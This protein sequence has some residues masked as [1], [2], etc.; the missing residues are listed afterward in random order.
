MTNRVV[1]NSQLLATRI[2]Q[3][4]TA[5]G[6]S[7]RA[8][9]VAA[10]VDFSWIARLERGEYRSPDPRCLARLARALGVEPA[11]LYSTAGYDDGLPGFAPYLRAKYELPDEAVRQ[12]EGFFELINERYQRQEGGDDAR[13][14]DA[15][16]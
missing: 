4:R 16:A 9:A 10:G 11:E 13:H 7:V 6:L 15:P 14:H 3:L 5:A 8:L 2:R 1:N 12:L